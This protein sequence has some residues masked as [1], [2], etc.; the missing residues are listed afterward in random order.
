MNYTRPL[1]K[2]SCFQQHLVSCIP[3]WQ[4]IVVGIF[5]GEYSMHVWWPRRKSFDDDAVRGGVTVRGDVTV[6]DF[7]VIW[8]INNEFGYIQ[9]WIGLNAHSI[10]ISPNRSMNATNA[11]W[12]RIEFGFSA[13]LVWEGLKTHT[14]NWVTTV[15]P[16]SCM[17]VYTVEQEM[18]L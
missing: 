1:G 3:A 15:Q 13:C 14:L 6:R 2:Q 8:W 12:M 11:H 5:D 4:A 16:G 10:C 17:F 9:R 18:A 7:I